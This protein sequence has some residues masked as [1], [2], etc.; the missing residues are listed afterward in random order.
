MRRRLD[1][2]LSGRQP[3][4]WATRAERGNAL[5][6]RCSVRLA[7]AL[8]RPLGLFLLHAVSLY[9]LAVSPADRAGSRLFLRKVLGREPRLSDL[10]RHFH[11]FAT[12]IL[13][14][15]YL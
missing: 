3:S 5:I 9:F 14:R 10:F 1:G 8:G 11:S 12:P 2:E 6:I 7:L 13:D 4:A 15:A